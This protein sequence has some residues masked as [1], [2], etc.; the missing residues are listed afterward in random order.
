MLA[1]SI[2]SCISSARRDLHQHSRACWPTHR[3]CSVALVVLAVLAFTASDGFVLL[4]CL[5]ITRHRW[6]MTTVTSFVPIAYLVAYW[7][8]FVSYSRRPA[9]SAPSRLALQPRMVTRPRPAPGA[10]DRRRALAAMSARRY[11]GHAMARRARRGSCRSRFSQLL[12]CLLAL[13]VGRS[14]AGRS[15]AA[16]MQ[17]AGLH[18]VPGEPDRA[19]L[20]GQR[21]PTRS[22]RHAV[23]GGVCLRRHRPARAPTPDRQPSIERSARAAR[24]RSR[25]LPVS[26]TR[27]GFYRADCR[28]E[29]ALGRAARGRASTSFA[30]A[31]AAPGRR[32]ARF[33]RG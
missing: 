11:A 6:C 4:L 19:A 13:A 20:R 5:L 23:G 7:P 33:R 2:A 24:R 32:P 3:A 16:S 10:R 14:S 27:P 28:A 29:R 25:A 26:V 15:C 30:M 8:G 18:G 17:R 21:V 1:Q 22:G 31:C 12:A 9:P